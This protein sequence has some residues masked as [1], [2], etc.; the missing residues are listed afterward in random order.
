M[1]QSS[2]SA[3][4][5][6]LVDD[7]PLMRRATSRLLEALG[8]E[9]RVAEDGLDAEAQLSAW[10]AAQVVL[11]DVM[12]PGRPAAETFAALRRV[13]PGIPVII[14]SGYA[15]E[16]VATRLLSEPQVAHLQKPFSRAQLGEAI[17]S[18]LRR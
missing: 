16:E 14:C 4:S 11:L 13:R 8:F 7:D 10:G 15:P 12:M 3:G 2:T 18:L 9:V 17:A 6:L 1:V 5:V